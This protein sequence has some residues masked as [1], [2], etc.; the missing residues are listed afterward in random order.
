MTSTNDTD[1]SPS[2]DQSEQQPL[3]LTDTSTRD[4]MLHASG[5][6]LDPSLLPAMELAILGPRDTT[7]T[8]ESEST[9]TT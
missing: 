5:D 4:S 2:A 6:R 7:S 1:T 3:D 9:S 8:T